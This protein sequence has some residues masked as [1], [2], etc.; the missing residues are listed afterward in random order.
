MQS[1]EEL[2]RSFGKSRL[3]ILPSARGKRVV[4]T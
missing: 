2:K 3:R 4:E 1:G